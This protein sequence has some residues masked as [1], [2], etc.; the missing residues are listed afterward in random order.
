MAQ[1]VKNLTS[2]HENVGSILG[3]AQ[4]VK[5]VSV[6]MSCSIGPAALIQPTALGISICLRCGPKRAKNK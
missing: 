1:R 4:W 6:A 5:G 2:I 3:F